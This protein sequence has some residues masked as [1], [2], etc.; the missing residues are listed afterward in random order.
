[1]GNATV[2]LIAQSYRNYKVFWAFRD[3]QRLHIIEV[4]SVSKRS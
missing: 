4:G 3:V 1:M 2:F